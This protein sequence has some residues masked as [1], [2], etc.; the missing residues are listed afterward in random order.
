MR[1]EDL[2]ADCSRCFGLCCVAP[3]FAKS[4]D[5]A[6]DKPAGHACPNLQSDFGCSIHTALRERGFAGCSTFDCFGAGQRVSQM[7]FGGHDWRSR[8]ESASAMFAAFA[9]ARTLHELL[10]YL[11]QARQLPTS[12]ALRAELDRA[13]ADVEATVGQ[14][15]QTLRRT[16]VASVR[17]EVNELLRAASGR[18]RADIVGAPDHRGADLVGANLESARLRGADLR[19]AQLIGANLTGA[20]LRRAD[21]TGADLRNAVLNGADL[22][23][24]LFVTPAQLASARGDRLTQLPSGR[25]RPAHWDPRMIALG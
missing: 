9:I 16:D 8:G 6:I 17:G 14:D 1:A 23:G 7:T 25:H 20:D 19:G 4:A 11:D 10:W 13:I 24:A 22:R 2:E 3:A 12:A 18:A 15:E 21:L 5:F